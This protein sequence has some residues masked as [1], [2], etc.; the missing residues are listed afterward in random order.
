MGDK[1]AA[2]KLVG[3]TDSDSGVV[4]SDGDQ[5]L[6][7]WNDLQDV[8]VFEEVEES[9]DGVKVLTEGDKMPLEGEVKYTEKPW[10]GKSSELNIGLTF[11]TRNKVR[12]FVTK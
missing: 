9:C 7:A 10:D 12:E 5:M 8:E 11:T 2:P 6:Q 3:I 1:E 4:V